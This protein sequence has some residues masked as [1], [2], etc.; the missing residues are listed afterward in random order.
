MSVQ[1]TCPPSFSYHQPR[2]L[3]ETSESTGWAFASHTKLWKA[4][5]SKCG[6]VMRRCFYWL[7][8]SSGLAPPLYDLTGP[9]SP[10]KELRSVPSSPKISS[11][12]WVSRDASKMRV[13]FLLTSIL[14]LGVAW[15]RPPMRLGQFTFRSKGG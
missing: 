14:C 7:N 8:A 4:A 1:E 12:W 6:A 10:K 9:G 3:L 13:G 5:S 11:P 15:F 2:C